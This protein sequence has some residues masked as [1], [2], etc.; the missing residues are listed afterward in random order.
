MKQRPF[1]VI[2]K[3]IIHVSDSNN[4][5]HDDVSVINEWHKVR[6]KPDPDGVYCGYHFFIRS[7]G[8]VQKGRAIK[9]YGQHCTGQ[10]WNSIG[11]CLHGKSGEFTQEQYKSLIDLIIDLKKIVPSILEVAQHSN[12][13]SKKPFCAGFKQNQ[14]DYLDNLIK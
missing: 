9:W 1:K 7:D 6:F 10:N 14:I 4:P 12:Y 13:D 8:N 2:D 3:I 5:K 11:I